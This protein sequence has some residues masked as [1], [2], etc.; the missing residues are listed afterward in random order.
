MVRSSWRIFSLSHRQWNCQIR[1]YGWLCIAMHQ[2]ELISPGKRWSVTELS[3]KTTYWCFSALIELPFP[4]QFSSCSFGHSVV[5]VCLLLQLLLSNTNLFIGHSLL[6]FGLI[7]E[8]SY[9]YRNSH[10]EFDT[11][12]RVCYIAKQHQW[13]LDQGQGGLPMTYDPPEQCIAPHSSENPQSQRWGLTQKQHTWQR[14]G[15]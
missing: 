4:S 15:E 2:S 8:L 1:A 6:H 5:Y 7:L 10:G 3:V 9:Q 12:G 11:W 13:Y 14:C